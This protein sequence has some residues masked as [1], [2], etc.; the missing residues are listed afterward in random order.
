MKNRD[1]QIYR[2]PDGN[3]FE[4]LLDISTRLGAVFARRWMGASNDPGRAEIS[5]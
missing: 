2:F 5:S 4:Q 1:F 3:H